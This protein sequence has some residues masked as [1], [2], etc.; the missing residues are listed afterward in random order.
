MSDL[1]GNTEDRFSHNKAHLFLLSNFTDLKELKNISIKYDINW[2]D[3][4]VSI[5]FTNGECKKP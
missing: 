1:V 3:I 4:I 5:E 2:L